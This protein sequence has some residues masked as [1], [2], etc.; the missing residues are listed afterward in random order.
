[1]S[2]LVFDKLNVAPTAPAIGSVSVYMKSDGV[3]YGRGDDGGEYPIG[4][5]PSDGGAGISSLTSLDYI[6][7]DTTTAFPNLA[8]RMTWNNTD[9]TLNLGMKGGNV[10]LQIGQEQLIRITNNTG[11]TFTSPQVVRLSGSQG[12]RLTVALAQ[13]NTESASR[14]TFAIITEDVPHNTEGFATVSGLVRDVNTSAFLEGDS[15]YLSATVL[16]GLTSVKPI[17]PL[18]AVHV[19]WCIRSHVTLGSIFVDVENGYELDELHDV[20]VSNLVNNDVLTWDTAANVWKNTQIGVKA[21]VLPTVTK[22]ANYTVTNSD[23]TIRVNGT[24]EITITLP[25]ATTNTGKIFI[26]K[27]VD[28]TQFKV[29]VNTTSSQLIDGSLTTDLTLQYETLTYQSNGTGYDIL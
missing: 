24:S 17:S 8:G 15:L 10:T 20:L 2:Q 1:M 12:Q 19:G 11:V 25:S 5:I 18:H 7:F 21:S 29:I 26:V 9:G 4:P 16:G 27:K 28:S 13:A 14:N 22:T 23:Y 3:M 6:D